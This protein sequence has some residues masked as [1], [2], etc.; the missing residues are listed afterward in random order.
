M[1]GQ[2]TVYSLQFTVR[3]RFTISPEP[4]HGKSLTANARKTENRERITRGIYA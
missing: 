1:S 4:T 3:F 2:F